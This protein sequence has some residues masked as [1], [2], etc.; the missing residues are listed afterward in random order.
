MFRDAVTYGSSLYLEEC[1]CI[2]DVTV[3]RTITAH[4][5]QK[6]WMTAKV[7]NLLRKSVDEAAPFTARNNLSQTIRAAQ[8]AD[9][10]K[11]HGHFQNTGDT[12]DIQA[13]THS[14]PSQ[15]I[16][17]KSILRTIFM[18]WM[19]QQQGRQ[20]CWTAADLRRSLLRV[21]PKLLDQTTCLAK[22]SESVLIS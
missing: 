14:R 22:S 12:W 18:H 16:W 19:T 15:T 17:A 4:P 21:N 11:I 10:Q 7:H 1:K 9:T 8:R 2:D 3:S 6:P 5:K 20:L 13:I